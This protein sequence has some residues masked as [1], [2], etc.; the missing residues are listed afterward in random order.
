VLGEL[1]LALDDPVDLVSLDRGDPF[2]DY[3]ETAG[4]LVAV[5]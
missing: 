4:E 5:G 2:G 3:L 1:M